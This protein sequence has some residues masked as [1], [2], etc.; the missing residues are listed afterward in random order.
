VGRVIDL[1]TPSPEASPTPPTEGSGGAKGW[2]ASSTSTI[3]TPLDFL[4]D[5][6]LGHYGLR[7]K[8]RLGGILNY[9]H[10]EAA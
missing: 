1:R 6:V 10:C 8:Q 2:V 3:A 9:Y 5:R 4:R 7:R